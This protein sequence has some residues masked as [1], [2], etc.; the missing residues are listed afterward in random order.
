M[1][2]ASKKI[3]SDLQNLLT[4]WLKHLE[5]EP[6]LNWIEQ[7]TMLDT[8]TETTE[9]NAATQCACT[10]QLYKRMMDFLNLHGQV[11]RQVSE[12]ARA[13]HVIAMTQAELHDSGLDPTDFDFDKISS[14]EWGSLSLPKG[15]TSRASTPDVIEEE[16]ER[17][18][19]ENN[20]GYGGRL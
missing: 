17:Y 16:P 4:E 12:M 9:E 15:E 3:Q 5:F 2:I 20:R 7:L 14:S 11:A 1:D 19:P 18:E 8:V 13:F 6:P 10:L